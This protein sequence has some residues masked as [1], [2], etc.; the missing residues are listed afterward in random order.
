MV[1]RRQI[2]VLF[3]V[4][5]AFGSIAS[6][7]PV[8]GPAPAPQPNPL[9]FAST[10]SVPYVSSAYAYPYTYPAVYSYGTPYYSTYL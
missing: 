1:F 2:T 5:I 9:L 4:A 8:P 10:Y 3:A 7:S 6:A